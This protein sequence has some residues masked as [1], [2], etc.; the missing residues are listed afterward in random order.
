[1]NRNYPGL[2]GIA[3]VR[4]LTGSHGRFHRIYFSQIVYQTATKMQALARKLNAFFD[5]YVGQRPT[6]PTQ[7][8]CDQ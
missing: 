4:N 8:R 7:Q 6:A 1:M 3:D 5:D 2:F